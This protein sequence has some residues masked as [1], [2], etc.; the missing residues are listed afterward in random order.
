M[1]GKWTCSETVLWGNSN[2]CCS[3]LSSL[4]NTKHEAVAVVQSTQQTPHTNQQEQLNPE[5][6][7]RLA[8]WSET[9]G[10]ARSHR[11]HMWNPVSFSLWSQHKQSSAI[12]C[13]VNHTGKSSLQ[14]SKQVKANQCLSSHYLLGQIYINFWT[15]CILSCFCYSKT[16][17]HLCLLQQNI[18]PTVCPSKTSL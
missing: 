5:E 14:T 10:A 11:N 2:L 4:A 16:S 7:V 1:Q 6:T 12:Q 15:S 13:K 18:L 3:Q 8:S 9:Q 17:F